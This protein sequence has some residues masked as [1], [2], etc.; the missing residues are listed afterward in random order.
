MQHKDTALLAS[1][2]VV[3]IED[4]RELC[5]ALQFALEI[6][7]YAVRCYADAET[8]LQSGDRSA[9][10]CLVVDHVLPGMSGLDLLGRLAADGAAVSAILI[11]SNPGAAVRRRAQAAGVPIVE[12]PLLGNAL[13]EAIRSVFEG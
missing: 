8:Y 9:Q 7:G 6:E 12:K 13:G 4:D 10:A 1:R 3:V 11:T 2:L 5:R